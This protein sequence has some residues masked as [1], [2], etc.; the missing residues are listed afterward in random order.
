[1]TSEEEETIFVQIASY[2]DPQLVPT[3]LDCLARA[4]H[5][6]LLFFGIAWQHGLEEVLPAEWFVSKNFAIVDIPYQD[7]RG[8][9]WARHQLQQRYAG[10]K[11]TL[12]LD[13]HHRFVDGWDVLLIQ[14]MTELQEAGCPKPLLTSYLPS[15]DPENDPEKRCDFP[16]ELRFMEFNEKGVLLMKPHKLKHW[17]HRKYPAPARFYSA[18]FCFTLG[19]FC[20]EVPHDPSLYFHGEEVSIAVRAFTHGYDLFHPHRV[21]AWHEYTRK[22]RVKQWDQDPTWSLRDAQSQARIGQLFS[23]ADLGL[24]GVGK[25]RTLEEYETYAGVSFARREAQDVWRPEKK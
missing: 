1:M 18:H 8:A 25:R 10:Q 6:H 16:Y 12:Q 15:F 11:Y 14:W 4:R 13:S 9:C 20:E 19:I 23:G 22:N 21:V 2:R 3:V 24:Y 5:P 17:R 7:S